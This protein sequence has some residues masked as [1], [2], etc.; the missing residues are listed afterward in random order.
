MAQTRSSLLTEQHRQM[1][2]LRLPVAATR[3]GMVAESV[4]RAF[5]P[6]WTVVFLILAP[7]MMGWHEIAPLEVVWGGGVIGIIAFLAALIWGARAFEMPTRAAAVDRVDAALPGRPIAAVADNQA[8]GSGDAA[9]EAVWQAHMARMADQTKSARAIQPDLRVS[10]RDPYGIRFIALLFFVTALLFGSFLRVGTVGDV[11]AGPEPTLVTGPVWEGWVEPPAYTGKPSIYLNDIPAGPLRVP[12]GS[13]VTLRLYGEVGAL[14]V[15][16][17]V[18]GRTGEVGPASD[19]QQQFVVTQSGEL[20][21]LGLTD[22]TWRV[23]AVADTPP[24]VELTGPIEADAM[25][26]LSQPFAAFDDYGVEA[27]TATI[28]LDL[29]AVD[30]RHGL[31]IDPDPIEPLVL[32]LP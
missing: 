17:T 25:G 32:D 11:V 10:D 14:T 18:S 3:L 27:G 24:T 2:H 6:L 28:T 4:V 13:E 31:T 22:T 1:R 9:S 7:L 12:A 5:W 26:E 20:S 16:E 15:A 30:R 8:I 21:I 19:A 23:T 29:A